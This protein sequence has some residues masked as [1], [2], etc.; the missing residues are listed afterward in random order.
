ME[1][2]EACKKRNPTR[3]GKRGWRERKDW[4]VG[5]RRGQVDFEL[6]ARYYIREG[7]LDER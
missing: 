6:G 1:A 2:L 7:V 4:G 3:A 5:G